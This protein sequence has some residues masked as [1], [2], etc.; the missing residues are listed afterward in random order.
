MNGRVTETSP[1]ATTNQQ[2]AHQADGAAG[3]LQDVRGAVAPEAAP[4]FIWSG[5]VLL[6][7]LALWV[8][9]RWRRRRAPT[10]HVAAVHDRHAELARLADDH[11][12]GRLTPHQVVLALDALVRAAL[13]ETL[14]LP[15]AS[16]TA[17]ELR[18]HPELPAP[19]VE[20]LTELLALC[21]A[22][23]FGR[24][25]PAAG[26]AARALQCAAEVLRAVM[27]VSPVPVKVGSARPGAAAATG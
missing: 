18:V 12:A 8:L 1:S 11:H 2:P 21:D 24:V 13:A 4:P 17:Q 15:S 23:K 6:L 7:A 9:V 25:Q 26:Q 19:A 14:G 5:A 20:P 16:L 3:E 10:P 22:A 27:P